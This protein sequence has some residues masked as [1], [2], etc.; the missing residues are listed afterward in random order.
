MFAGFAYIVDGGKEIWKGNVLLTEKDNPQ[1][2][3]EIVTLIEEFY[4]VPENMILCRMEELYI[5][6]VTR[7]NSSEKNKLFT[8]CTKEKLEVK[9]VVFRL[10]K[11][12]INFIWGF[13]FYVS[14]LKISRR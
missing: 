5:L 14:Q 7:I 9:C 1:W 12:C 3:N 2:L 13:N 11:P 8:G 10:M 4:Q 6:F